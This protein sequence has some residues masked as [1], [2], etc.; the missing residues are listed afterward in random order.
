MF[1]LLFLV[2]LEL[3]F[4]VGNS[5]SQKVGGETVDGME[6]GGVMRR[7]IFFGSIISHSRHASDGRQQ[8][9]RPWHCPGSQ[10]EILSL[11]K[12]SHDDEVLE[13]E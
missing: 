4:G 9:S 11:H 3:T 8:T 12:P 1:Q 6:H 13:V 5:F 2:S 10:R 7:R